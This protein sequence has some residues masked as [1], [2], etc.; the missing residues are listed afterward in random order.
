MPQPSLFSAQA[1]TADPADLVGLLCA[2]GQVHGFGRGTAARVSVVVAERWRAASI[3][4]ACVDRGLPA[5]HGGTDGDRHWARTA[6]VAC[7]L[8]LAAAWTRGAVKAVPDGW[9]L[10]GGALRLWV[11]AAGAPD[12]RGYMLGLDSHAP[13]THAALA[14]ALASAGLTATQLGVRAG[15]PALRMSGRKRL[16]RLAELVGEAPPEAPPGCWPG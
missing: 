6:F 10:D 3:A 5:E 14:A 11:L 9:Q 12:G 7:L 8:P 15:G 1:R 16:A 4:A 13:G 2:H